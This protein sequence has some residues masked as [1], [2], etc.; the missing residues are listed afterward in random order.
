MTTPMK[1]PHAGGTAQ[2]RPHTA[3]PLPYTISPDPKGLVCRNTID[4]A[5]QP[6]TAKQGF[7]TSEFS[8]GPLHPSMVS[9]GMGHTARL[10]AW[11]NPCYEHPAPS[12]RVVSPTGDFKTY[13]EVKTVNPQPKPRQAPTPE[14]LHEAALNARLA[15]AHIEHGRTAKAQRR[16][17]LALQSLNQPLK[18]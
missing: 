18:G 13:S 16:L 9:G 1:A 6:L 5:V 3:S 17:R 14:R 7:V 2:Y 4:S 15:L 10:A 8:G 11:L 12:L